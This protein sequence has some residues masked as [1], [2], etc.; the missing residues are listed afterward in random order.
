MQGLIGLLKDIGVQIKFRFCFK[1]KCKKNG[2]INHAILTFQWTTNKWIS[3]VVRKTGANG[4]VIDGS[5]LCIEPT[6]SRTR[7]NTFIPNY[8]L[9]KF[10][11]CY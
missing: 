11:C 5:T 10:N 2:N 9:V 7:V 6:H 3:N 8:K 4:S 1:K